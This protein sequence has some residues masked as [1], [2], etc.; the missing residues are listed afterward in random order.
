[1]GKKNTAAPAQSTREKA[2]AL[3][4]AQ[5]KADAK[6]R[7]ILIAVVAALVSITVLASVWVVWSAKSEMNANV[8]P[9]GEVTEFVVSADGVGKEKS[10]VP[11]LVEYFDYSCH[12]CADVEGYIG[13]QVTDAA[14]AG[15]YNVKFVPVTVVGMPW[16]SV[17]AHAAYL[18]YKESPE[19]FVTFH[20]ELLAFFKTQF[21]SKN[22]SV[23][24]NEDASLAKIK[25]IATQVGVPAA[26][27]EKFQ[28]NG[29]ADMLTTNH[30]AWKAATPE[31]R[32]GLGTPE[33][34][35]NNKVVELNGQSVEELYQNLEKSILGQ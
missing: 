3:R 32:T 17:A 2:E 19:N 33:F 25:E 14:A 28:K 7:N 24:Q 29:A 27:V 10:G 9:S 5:A 30:Q 12:A 21:D 31:G 4:A 18:T 23:I 35:V 22:V 16:N 34:Q 1:M 8:A 15:K 6:T 26:T 11:T 20:H 13:K